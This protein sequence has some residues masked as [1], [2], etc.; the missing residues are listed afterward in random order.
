VNEVFAIVPVKPLAEGK[1]RLSTILSADQRTE[2]NIF[3]MDLTLE[4]AAIF[5]GASRTIVVSRSKEVLTAAAARGMIPLL[6]ETDDLNEA[7]SSASRKAISLGATGVL[8]LP[9]DLPLAGIAAIRHHI[10]RSIRPVCVIAPDRHRSGTNLLYLSPVRDDLYRFGPDSFHKHQLEAQQRALQ[11]VVVEDDSLAI[12]I[13]ETTD[14]RLWMSR[15]EADRR[16]P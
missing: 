2:L 5:P 12:D 8:I 6:E 13:D 7:L 9:V 10:E 15:L 3:L 1:S 14:Y 4:R 16:R 11:V